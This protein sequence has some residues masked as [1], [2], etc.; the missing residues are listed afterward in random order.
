MNSL[1]RRIYQLSHV[2]T[3]TLWRGTADRMLPVERGRGAVIVTNHRSSV[4]PFF[5]Q[6]AVGPQLV[7]WMVAKEYVEH[8]VFGWY[9]RRAETIPTSRA[10]IDTAATKQAIRYAAGGALVGMLPEGRINMTDD[11]LLPIRPGAALIALRARVPLI[12][13][14]IDGA[15]YYKMTYSPFFMPAR[16]RVHVGD[17]IDVSAHFDRDVEQQTAAMLTLQAMREVARLA[18]RE[19]FEPQL[20]GRRWKPTKEE[21]EQAMDENDRRQ[22]ETRRGS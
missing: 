18:G 12:P 11:F 17:P 8:P 20:A 3:R 13:C 9:L 4:D 2:L 15:P 22:R 21:L 6:L 14:Y 16:V 10:G 5:I 1:Q 7:H 19:D